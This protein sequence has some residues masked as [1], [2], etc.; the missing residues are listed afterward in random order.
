MPV[1]LRGRRFLCQPDGRG[2]AHTHARARIQLRR[3]RRDA[4]TAI[5]QKLKCSIQSKANSNPMPQATPATDVRQPNNRRSS[6]L[7]VSLTGGVSILTLRK[8]PFIDLMSLPT[9]HVT[10]PN[11]CRDDYNIV[12]NTALR[13]RNRE[14]Y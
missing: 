5:G 3:M 4:A 13:M 8:I 9:V 6:S 12:C 11:D 10:F 1:K 14:K 7:I 2:R